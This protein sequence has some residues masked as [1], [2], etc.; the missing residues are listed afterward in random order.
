MSTHRL[1]RSPSARWLLLTSVS[2]L[3]LLVALAGRAG[4]IDQARRIHDR[5]VGVP[6]SA[7]TLADMVAFLPDQPKLAA[8]R[9]M[10]EPAFYNVT[11]KN[12][13]TP[14]TNVQQTVYADLNDYTALVIGLIRDE[15]DFREVLT[16]DVA[17]VGSS[18]VSTVPY[19]QTDN[20]HYVELEQN[21]VDLSNPANLVMTQQSALPGAVIGP[22][23][24]AGIITT[25]Q[26]GLEFF[27]AGTNRRMWRFIAINYLCRDMEQLK[28]VSRETDRIRQDVS[29]SPGGDSRIFQTQCVGCH[30]GMDPMT[31]AFAYF[32]WD[33]TAGRTVFTPGN[34]QQKY[35]INANTFPGGYITVDD[36]WDDFWRN[37]ANASLGWRGPNAGGY[38]PKSLGEEV[39]DSRAFSVCQVEKVFKQVCYRPPRD[40]AEVQVVRDIADDF[41]TSGYRMKTVFADVAVH[42]MGN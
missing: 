25:R 13:I 34:V 31:G 36:R 7:Q 22:N 35:L 29:R 11:L 38:G 40:D 24:A 19:S 39:A 21:R 6:P 5:L 18:Q 20:L 33:D 3:S 23:D 14:W 10:Q 9:A 30:S 1:A 37:G 42:C 16:G 41:E 15:R 2:S 8:E 26:A 32:D 12:F 4:P 17:Y 27:K 28:D